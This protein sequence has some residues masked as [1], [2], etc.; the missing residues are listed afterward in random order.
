MTLISPAAPFATNGNWNAI[1]GE[2][3]WMRSISRGMELPALMY[4]AWS[5]PHE[6]YQLDHFGGIVVDGESLA[7]YAC[8]FDVVE[9]F[10]GSRL[11]QG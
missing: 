3:E 7:R 4:A 1:N 6:K 10:K 11:G 5:N 9:A 2:I 8:T